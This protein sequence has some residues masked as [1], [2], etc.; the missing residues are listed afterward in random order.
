MISRMKGISCWRMRELDSGLRRNDG[1]PS[2]G[3]SPIL[4]QT[5]IAGN[6]FAI[7]LREPETRRRPLRGGDAGGIP[8]QP[9]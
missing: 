5:I 7:V 2:N 4:I 8:R 3:V 1:F 6:D 9:V